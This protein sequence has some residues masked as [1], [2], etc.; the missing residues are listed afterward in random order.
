MNAG[1]AAA[2]SDVVAFVS[3]DTVLPRDWD[4]RLLETL[5]DDSVGIAA[6]AITGGG[7]ASSILTE[8]GDTARR[9]KPFI[10][11][12]SGVVYAART[13]FMKS[14]GG[15]REDYAVASSEDLD[16]LFTTWA[17]GHEVLID[18]RVLVEHI[19][20]ATADTQLTNRPQI[21]RRNRKQFA[22]TWSSMDGPAFRSRYDWSAPVSEERLS[23]ARIAAY[24]MGRLFDADD[25]AA[26][27]KWSRVGSNT[28]PP[29]FA[30]CLILTG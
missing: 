3:N 22:E 29:A 5:A 7:N 19:G 25:E 6:P 20:R 9:A 30:H 15:W 13:P 28:N 24:W 21:W 27:L 2:R 1:L 17:T 11:L 4:T 12:P 14:L 18:D 26:R 10:D 16:L 8:P 23:Q